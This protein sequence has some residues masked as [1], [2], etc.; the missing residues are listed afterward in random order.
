MRPSTDERPPLFRLPVRKIG[1]PR[2]RRAAIVASYPFMFLIALAASLTNIC[3]STAMA[4]AMLVLYAIRITIS[5]Q[6]N[7]ARSAGQAW[8]GEPLP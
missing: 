4:I 6:R 7:L 3:V 2:L 8:R 5:Q 1:R